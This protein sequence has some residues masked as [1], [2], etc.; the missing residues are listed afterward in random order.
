MVDVLKEW[1]SNHEPLR[2]NSRDFW[3]SLSGVVLSLHPAELETP[4]RAVGLG[5]SPKEVVFQL[6]NHQSQR[7]ASS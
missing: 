1:T 2:P 3:P 7:Q 6:R 5:L 4:A